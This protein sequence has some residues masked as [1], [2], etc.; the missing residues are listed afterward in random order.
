VINEIK[1][2]LIFDKAQKYEVMR[3]NNKIKEIKKEI[4][5]KIDKNAQQFYNRNIRYLFD[6]LLYGSIDKTLI[7]CLSFL[8]ELG[9]SEDEYI[10]IILQSIETIF[11]DKSAEVN[12]G[13]VHS[14]LVRHVAHCFSPGFAPKYF[15]TCDYVK[16]FHLIYLNETC[17]WQV[18]NLGNY[19]L[20]LNIMDALSFIIVLLIISNHI[21]M[22]AEE[23]IGKIRTWI[24]GAKI[25]L[26][27]VRHVFGN[28]IYRG[29]GL[30]ENIFDKISLT[31]Y[32][33]VILN[34]IV[35]NYGKYA[36]II[37]TL[38]ESELLG[39]FMYYSPEVFAEALDIF[40]TSPIIDE[41]FIKKF[42]ISINYY[43]SGDY[44]LAYNLL[45]P[46]VEEL[47]NIALVKANIDYSKTR[48]L[49]EK[50]KL[51]EDKGIL[52]D[53][54]SLKMLVRSV[55]NYVVHGEKIE[56]IRLF[57]PLYQVIVFYMV[58]EIK[59]MANFFSKPQE[60]T[61]DIG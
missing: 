57:I 16:D 10:D 31:L 38:L 35:K 51:L 4:F 5:K 19:F 29:F 47:I 11:K 56:D 9:V 46:Q 32:G 55:R 40:K 28:D 12:K 36:T 58:R 1:E 15:F 24:N 13:S 59:I 48:G 20:R 41:Q 26:Q 14:L 42:E 53:N 22:S 8:E 21:Y 45:I 44:E 34:N 60:C 50:F 23:K 25:Y 49:A 30:F 7:F 39:D 33:E 17:T 61:C 37:Q 27:E 52:K 3:S 6:N 54:T 43:K 2:Y 18:S